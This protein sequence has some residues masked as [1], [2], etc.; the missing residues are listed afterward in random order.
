VAARRDEAETAPCRVGLVGDPDK[1]TEPARVAEGQAGQVEQQ[2]PGGAG[3][4]GV[5]LG[6]HALAGGE[7]QLPWHAQDLDPSAAVGRRLVFAWAHRR[8]P[9]VVTIRRCVPP[10]IKRRPACLFRAEGPGRNGC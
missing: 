10:T 8:T 5:A 1:G 9:S 2:Q 3:D 7:I 6:D 4:G